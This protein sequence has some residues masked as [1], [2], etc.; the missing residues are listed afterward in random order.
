MCQAGKVPAHVA[1]APLVGKYHFPHVID[2]GTKAQGGY[3]RAH[4]WQCCPWVDSSERAVCGSLWH[5]PG[6]R[7]WPRRSLGV[8]GGGTGAAVGEGGGPWEGGVAV[9][10]ASLDMTRVIT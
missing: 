2:D 6:H 4:R 10:R 9:G 3:G 5:E 1:I 8:P 7:V